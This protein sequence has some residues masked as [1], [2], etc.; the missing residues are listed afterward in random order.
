[1]DTVHT[2]QQNSKSTILSTANDS[3]IYLNIHNWE[4]NQNRQFHCH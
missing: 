4:R 1:M 3:V 2:I